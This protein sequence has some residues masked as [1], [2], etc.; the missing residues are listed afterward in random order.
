MQH[1][2][3]EADIGVI[4]STRYRTCLDFISFY[5]SLYICV[6]VCVCVVLCSLILCMDLCNHRSQDST[7]PAPKQ[8]PPVALWLWYPPTPCPLATTTLVSIYV[9]SSF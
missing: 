4:V 2:N 7:A 6:C 5:M 9:V 8:T 3:Q 1:Q